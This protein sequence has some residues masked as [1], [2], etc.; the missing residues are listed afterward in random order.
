MTVRISARQYR[1]YV[2]KGEGIPAL[3]PAPPG[4]KKR[5]VKPK[6]EPKSKRAGKYNAKGE[7]RHGKWFASQAQA[8]RW[9][10]LVVLEQLGVIRSLRHEV[11][12]ILTMNGVHVC[13]YRADAVYVVV[14]AP[15]SPQRVVIEDTKGFETKEFAIKQRL[16]RANRTPLSIVPA[17]E[18]KQWHMRIPPPPKA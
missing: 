18:V 10:Q 9:D 13:T 17:K 15:G 8:E 1:A 7:H 12:Y 5:E 2:E 4:R 14:E 16:M 3:C 11:P 6:K